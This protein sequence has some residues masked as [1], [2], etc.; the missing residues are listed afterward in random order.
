MTKRLCMGGVLLLLLI[1]NAV[2]E[3][4][5]VSPEG[6][7][8][9]P[10]TETAPFL[11]LNKARDAVRGISSSITNDITV[12]LRGG[13][14]RLESAFELTSADSGTN[15]HSVVY[16][17]YADELPVLCG[18][19][20]VTN[21]IA[22][23]SNGIYRASVGANVFRQLYVNGKRAVRA[24]TPNPEDEK[25]GGP[26]YRLKSWDT[27]NKLIRISSAEIN[28]WDRFRS[29][30]MVVNCVFYHCY[31]RLDS[32]STVDSNAFVTV[33]DPERRRIFEH[34]VWRAGQAYYFENALEFLDAA[35]EWY[36]NRD[37]GTL[38]YKPRQ[39]ED[40]SKAAVIA[41]ST[42]RLIT[43]HGGVS[44]PVHNIKFCGIGFEHTGWNA[45]DSE[46]VVATQAAQFYGLGGLSPASLEIEYAE[47]IYVE[48]CHFIHLGGAGINLK[49]GVK[50]CGFSGNFL[51]DISANG[52]VV[53]TAGIKNPPVEDQC[54]GIGISNNLITRIGRDY[55]S[56]VGIMSRYT[57]SMVIE[58]NEISNI[59][60]SGV[61]LGAG[62]TYDDTGMRNTIF[63]HNYIH[64]VMQLLV[65]GGGIYTLSSQPGTH[66]YE[67][68]VDHVYLS[69]WPAEQAWPVAALYA[70]EG[71]D[72]TVWENNLITNY[73]KDFH[74]NSSGT[75]NVITNNNSHSPAVRENA[76]LEADYEYL[77]VLQS[78]YP[79]GFTWDRFEEWEPGR[80]YHSAEGNP[81]DDA[82][83]NPVWQYEYVAGG[84]R[85][86]GI[87]PW[88]TLLGR[89][90]V[91]E[92]WYGQG[93][94]WAKAAGSVPIIK[95]GTLVHGSS[96]T[97]S[98]VVCWINPV[99]SNS[100]L[101]IE[102]QLK[103]DWRSGATGDVDLAI[104]RFGSSSN[105]F[106]ILFSDTLNSTSG[107]PQSV[108]IALERVAVHE[109]DRILITLKCFAS[110]GWVNLY[111]D[112]IISLIENRQDS[113]ADGMPD[114]WESANRMNPVAASDGGYDFDSDGLS[115]YG[116]Y[117][118]GTNPA[119][120][121]SRIIINDIRIDSPGCVL[122]F[123][124]VNGRQY[125]VDYR[126][127][128]SDANDWKMLANSIHGAGSE[129]EISDE[130]AKPHRFY[131]V[132]V[133]L[134]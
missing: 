62:H 124:G 114:R 44:N 47:N 133:E 18:G 78:E 118:A 28:A 95:S 109:N 24:R 122:S 79:L 12:Y 64:H 3:T 81:A 4:F 75:H 96:D 25:T 108:N 69:E 91:C 30:E 43:I 37:S 99:P 126:D 92:D 131:R 104:V 71:T 56:A 35:G 20:A 85:L 113:D 89:R 16:T 97:N 100:I 82:Y 53:D 105:S 27:T 6:S 112:L 115:N 45:P 34:P 103:V 94:V 90:L 80:V 67:N 61:N 106:D 26:F 130:S 123:Y 60:Y 102:G 14:Y 63:R 68:F 19:F 40:M 17:A 66:I 7:D 111:D 50:S 65:D 87:V 15:G 129:I 51:S 134:P 42:E 125:R 128:V 41:P 49:R 5:Y 84:D 36:L 77:Q 8:S 120:E 86:A 93:D 10:G 52:I 33:Q 101:K 83:N 2:S 23:G 117:I 48:R 32:Y 57:G 9:N 121:A 46:G 98:P 88:Y 70:D 58:H 59:F 38:F 31:L 74:I 55:K 76:G 119:D 29:V 73:T 116:E 22:T 132:L 72:Y 39:G 13:R 54:S 110:A 107:S 21:W 127:E 11:S 1:C